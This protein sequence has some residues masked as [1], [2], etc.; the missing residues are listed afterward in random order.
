MNSKTKKGNLKSHLQLE[1]LY[2]WKNTR[3]EISDIAAHGLGI[4]GP[5]KINSVSALSTNTL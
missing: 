3:K 5:F 2:K 1:T 4:R